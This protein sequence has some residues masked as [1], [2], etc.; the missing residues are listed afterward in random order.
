[1]EVKFDPKR[2]HS[3]EVVV[4]RLIMDEETERSRIVDSLETALRKGEGLAMVAVANE[5][6]P[7]GEDHLFSE[8]FAC[9]H[10]EISLPPIEPRLFS[11]NSPYGACEHCTG[12]GH[13]LEVDPDLVLPN[14][15]LTLEEGAI[16]PWARASHRVGRQSWYWYTLSDLAE[17]YGFS[18]S[19]PIKSLPKKD[20]DII[21]Y[22]DP[23]GNYEGVVPNLERR[24]KETE[25]E[26]TRAEVERYMTFEPCP[27]CKGKRLKPEALSVLVGDKNIADL[28]TMAAQESLDFI[29]K[30][31]REFSRRKDTQEIAGPLLKEVGARLQFLIDVGLEYL[32]LDR[33]STTLAG[34]EAQRVRP[35]AFLA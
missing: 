14:K 19:T 7:E 27:V 8:H 13:T 17:K 9:P 3:L 12:L 4:D 1:M 32:T 26:W 10:C 18:M 21:L 11:F 33:T 2:K 31:A 16:F 22:G 23:D 24:W 30:I 15:N 28:A 34:G 5:K 25:S 6:K 29:K 20:T 35:R